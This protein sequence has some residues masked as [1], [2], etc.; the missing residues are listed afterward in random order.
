MCV[1]DNLWRGNIPYPKS[2]SA[3]F[4]ITTNK[5]Q[6]ILDLF[7]STD[8]HHVSSSSSAQH[9]EH[10]NCIQLQLLSTNTAASCYRRMRWNGVP[11]QPTYATWYHTSPCL[12]IQCGFHI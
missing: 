2:Y 9:H 6:R 7:I 3:Y 8:A 1:K 11:S 4:Q 10:K 12:E 5:M